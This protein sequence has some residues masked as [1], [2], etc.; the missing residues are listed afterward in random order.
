MART[1]PSF[2]TVMRAELENGI[3]KQTVGDLRA[4][5]PMRYNHFIE[6]PRLASDARGRLWVT[7][8]TYAPK[9]VSVWNI[10]DDLAAQAPPDSSCAAAARHLG[11]EPPIICN[12]EL[13]LSSES[14]MHAK[15][16]DELRFLPR[17]VEPDL[18]AGGRGRADAG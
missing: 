10:P 5:I 7:E 13:R 9:R 14:R 16:T 4:A 1:L 18:E 6:A 17:R 3:W 2:A 8:M 15:V 11:G 12:S